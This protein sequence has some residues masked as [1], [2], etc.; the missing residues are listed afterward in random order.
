MT[1][2]IAM[3]FFAAVTFATWGISFAD[4]KPPL[5]KLRAEAPSQA[6]GKPKV[7]ARS[8]KNKDK[9]FQL[10]PMT[11]RHSDMEDCFTDPMPTDLYSKP[12]GEI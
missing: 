2:R 8:S 1:K 5:E 7:D 9:P 6:T 12:K 3:I 11:P 10:L 4:H